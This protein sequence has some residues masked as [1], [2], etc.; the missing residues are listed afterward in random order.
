MS[1]LSQTVRAIPWDDV[2]RY[3]PI[4][5]AS[6]A[7]AAAGFAWRAIHVQRSIARKRAA[8]DIFMKTEMDEK[9]LA[10]YYNYV[11]AAKHLDNV[12]DM[13]GFA[14]TE[15]YKT[16]RN[17]LN[18]HE[19]IAVGMYQGVLSRAI[20]HHFWS[21]LMIEAYDDC[22]AVIEHAQKEYPDTYADMV[23]FAKRWKKPAWQRCWR[24]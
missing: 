22:R 15:N 23:R 7:V 11:E 18:I 16:I 21:N 5:T 13:D 3:A 10:S 9:I 8:I 2:A 4:I 17:Y 12:G 14:R 20:C 24:A 1:W 19:L 6:V